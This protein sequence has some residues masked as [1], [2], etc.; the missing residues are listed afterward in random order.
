[1]EEKL[2]EGWTLQWSSRYNAPYYFH[3]SSGESR[4]GK[5]AEQAENVPGSGKRGGSAEGSEEQAGKRVRKVQE[6]GKE[7]QEVGERG[8][9]VAVVVPYRD[10]HPEQQRE[11]QLQRFYPFMTRCGGMDGCEVM[12]WLDICF[13][14]C[15]VWLYL[16][17][18][19]VDFGFFWG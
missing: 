11:A 5:P 19:W 2:P 12:R 4:W 8:G 1:M 16:S 15:V 10:L 17:C 3:A 18:F 9:R 13:F 6:E 7:G 14:W